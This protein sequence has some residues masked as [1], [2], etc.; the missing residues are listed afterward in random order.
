MTAPPDDT[1]TDAQ[2]VIAA[3]RAERDAALAREATLAEELAARD[4][5][6]AQRNGERI[7]Y[8]AATFDVL[9]AMSASP[10]DPQSVF[11]LIVERAR[12]FCDADQANLALLDGDMLHLEATTGSSASY[13]VQF[14]R[15]VDATSTFGRAIIARDAV[16]TADL[17]T[18]PYHFRRTMNSEVAVR[19][20]VAVPLLR[21]GAPV[22]AIVLG[23][24]I[25]G[26]FSATQVELLWTFAEQAVIA[27][28]SAE[29]YR[30]LQER[31]RSWRSATPNTKS[32]LSIKPRPLTC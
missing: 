31:P 1:R 28:T 32:G 17:R 7:E 6:L 16:Q 5:V 4:A 13:P 29:T 10:G 19:A 23:R 30:A 8:Q 22:G 2:A 12:A 27:I 3:L 14:P 24:N 26:E 21:S 15:P 20:I 11:Q 9:R 18:D 25:P